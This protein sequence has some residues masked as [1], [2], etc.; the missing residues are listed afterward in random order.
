MSKSIVNLDA[1][2]AP[3]RMQ[4]KQ[5]T[6]T[7]KL[8][9]PTVI[10]WVV[11]TVTFGGTYYFC[12]TG[13][14][15]LW[16]GTLLNTVVGYVSFSVIHDSIHRAVSSNARLNDAIG[17]AA[18]L[19]VLPYVD[20]RLFRWL[21]ILHHRYANGSRDPD[22]VLHGAWWTLPFRWMSIDLIYFIYALRYADKVSRPYLRT[23]LVMCAVVVAVLAVLIAE[24]YG[25][26]VLMLW[27]LPSRLIL[28]SLG[29]SFFWLPH[30]PHDIAQEENFTRA[31]TVRQGYEW[32]LGPMLQYQNYHLIHHLYPLTPFYNNYKVWQLIE[33]EL[34]KKDL[35]I[36]HNFHIMPV[37]Y[38]GRTS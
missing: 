2:T 7:P 26:Q 11:L 3:Q 4:F 19:L 28:L 5:L 33:P 16:V 34:R 36:Q 15:P 37:V 23:A 1:L 27:F 8:A 30:V 12:G 14:V 35:A 29:F 25:L 10:L 32:L 9:W 24:G 17:Q 18:M 6:S 21:H 38:P 31:T 13:R 22:W 20:T